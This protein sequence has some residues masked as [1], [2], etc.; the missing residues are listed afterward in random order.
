MTRTVNPKG[1]EGAIF[2]HNEQKI[3]FIVSMTT[4]ASNKSKK[5]LSSSENPY[6]Q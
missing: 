3:Y 2:E 1:F 4:G 6:S 5:A